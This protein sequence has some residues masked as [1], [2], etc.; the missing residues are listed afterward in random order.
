M[1]E[2]LTFPVAAIVSSK[3]SFNTRRRR[4]PT[5][6]RDRPCR[7][8][9]RYHHRRLFAH[10]GP[11]ERGL[12]APYCILRL[13]VR[14]PKPFDDAGFLAF[15]ELCRAAEALGHHQRR[16]QS[17]CAQQCMSGIESAGVPSLYAFS[18]TV[19]ARSARRVSSSPA[20]ARRGGPKTY[21]SARFASATALRTD[22]R[23]SSYV[24]DVMERRMGA[25]G[26]AWPTQRRRN[27]IP[28]TT[29]TTSSRMKSPRAAPPTRADVALLP[30]AGRCAGL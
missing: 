8:A 6:L 27:S 15:N 7:L 28:F 14:S 25:L 19:P 16:R 11:S 4:R 5:R 29:S 3:A 17:D 26:V 23:Q 18:Y 12:D 10:R 24:L 9:G 2:V 22:P 13:R 21:A 1:S 30:A 20:A